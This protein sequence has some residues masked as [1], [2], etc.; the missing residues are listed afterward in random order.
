MRTSRSP[1]PIEVC[2]QDVDVVVVE[3]DFLTDAEVKVHSRAFYSSL[4]HKSSDDGVADDDKAP[5][6]NSMRVLAQKQDLC[7][8]VR[9]M[10]AVSE[11]TNWSVRSGP[12]AKFKA[13]RCDIERLEPESPEYGS[14]RDHLLNTQDK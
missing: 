13:L 9:D 8:L 3:H 4:P 1:H 12:E 5:L 2:G 6:I 10:V 14:V 7:Q 11:T